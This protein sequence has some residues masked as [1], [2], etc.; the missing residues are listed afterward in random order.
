MGHGRCQE[1]SALSPWPRS[2]RS[3]GGGDQ[4]KQQVSD[5]GLPRSAVEGDRASRSWRGGDDPR[6]GWACPA[7]ARAWRG[8]AYWRR[9]ARLWAH[10]LAVPGW[11][12]GPA[13]GTRE[14][15]QAVQML[16]GDRA[17]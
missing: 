16:A 2:W 17:V 7:A 9:A 11:W 4:G 3:A 5:H 10:R 14:S 13:A 6:F 12:P 8:A 15:G 1:P